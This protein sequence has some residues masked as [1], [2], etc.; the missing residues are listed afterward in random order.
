MKLEEESSC[1]LTPYLGPNGLTLELGHL[2]TPISPS[3]HSCLA[4]I[5]LSLQDCT[6]PTCPADHSAGIQGTAPLSWESSFQDKMSESKAHGSQ[7]PRGPC[8][9]H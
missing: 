5:P 6:H 7:V 8:W 1:F 3:Y 2:Y 9:L 4:L